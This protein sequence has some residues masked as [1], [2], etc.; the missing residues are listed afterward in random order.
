MPA[1][2]PTILHKCVLAVP[3]LGTFGPILMIMGL[4]DRSIVSFGIACFGAVAT[5]MAL[6][7]LGAAVARL[8]QAAPKG[9]QTGGR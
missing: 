1:L 5:G 7:I 3:A 2:R 4:R 8:M 9:D 6:A